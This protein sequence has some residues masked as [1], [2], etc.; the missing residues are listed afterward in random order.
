MHQPCFYQNVPA[1][2]CKKAAI[3]IA[4]Q[5]LKQLSLAVALSSSGTKQSFLLCYEESIPHAQFKQTVA[6]TLPHKQNF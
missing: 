5:F 3:T 6:S 4:L 1:P 2:L